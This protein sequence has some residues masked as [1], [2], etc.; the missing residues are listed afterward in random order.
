[1]GG[2]MS[3]YLIGV[4]IG[5]QGTKAALFDLEMNMAGTAFRPS[6]LISP[7]PGVVWQDPE[8]MFQSCAS[9]LKELMHTTAINP[10]DVAGIG[11][12]GQMA[13]IMGIDE[14]GAASTVYDSWLDMRCG[15]YTEQMNQTAG[16][17]IIELSGGPATYVHGPKILW[18]KDNN[19]EEYKKTAKFV[20]PHAFIVGRMCA[21]DSARAYFDYTHLH[22]S[23]L[24]DNAGKRWSQELL[25]TFDISRDKM[26]RI[27]SPFEV[28][29]HLTEAFAGL[30]GLVP[31][32]PVVAGCGD[33]AA[34][35]FGTGMFRPGMIL[36]SAGTASVLCSVVDRFVP[37][38]AHATL[39]MMRSPVDGLFVPLAYINGGGMCLR[40]FRDQM[41]GSPA[42]TYDELQ[43]EAEMVECGSEGVLFIPHFSGRVL[44][45]NPHLKGSFSGLDFRH[46]R[47]HLYR[48]VME[49]VAYEYDYYLSVLRSLYPREQFNTMLTIG[50]GAKSSL[51][52]QIK[53]DVLGIKVSTLNTGETALIGS[54]VIAG[55]GVGALPDYAAPINQAIKPGNSFRPD[56]TNHEKY[57]PYAKAYLDAI[58]S[59]SAF[60]KHAEIYGGA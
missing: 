36:D 46:T 50:G 10:R 47:A 22:F 38:T 48:A 34:G 5:T 6:N 1:M 31:G 57:L 23:C 3:K 37:D 14:S 42:A 28:V 51:F 11:L 44:P 26:A 49:A 4:D 35:T 33:T 40:W 58:S 24:S 54:A 21:L 55:V 52:N 12:D 2:A 32:I 53:A 30:S 25:D 18:L 60:Y 39:T 41:T 45:G 19:P 7:R 13:G 27:V 17:R 43:S 20:L 29:G 9:A 16:R 59:L 56:D 15:P 8:E